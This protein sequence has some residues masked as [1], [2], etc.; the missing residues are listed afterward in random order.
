MEESKMNEKKEL[1]FLHVNT[2]I[3]DSIQAA[4]AEVPKRS[5]MYNW[6]LAFQGDIYPWKNVTKEMLKDYD[7]IQVNMSRCDLILVPQIRRV[8]NSMPESERPMLVLNNDYVCEFWDNFQLHPD[9]YDE[10]QKLGDMVFSTEHYQVSNMIEGTFCFPHP[11]NTK[12]LKKLRGTKKSNTVAFIYHWWC[13][14]TYTPWRIANKIKKKY[15]LDA[16]RIYAYMDPKTDKMMKFNKF[17]W[18]EKIGGLDFVD[19]VEHLAS[20][21]L[22][23]ELTPYHTYG[24]NTV[25]TACCKIPVIG[26]DRVFSCRENYPETSCDPYDG[27][28]IMR[29]ADKWMTDEKWA[30]RQIDM[31]F[32]K[33][34]YFNYENSR[35]RFMDALEICKKR[36]G[37]KYYQRH[38]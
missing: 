23:L 30:Q 14:D 19:Y 37:W 8:L 33:V 24:R 26:S 38:G 21:K 7:V 6:V 5:G 34:E 16:T 1:K 2:D 18:D 35:K 36:G 29:L 13:G 22:V 12:Y 17:M 27:E 9:E 10:L 32:E 11:T 31:A 4:M 20:N 3:T 25:E 15:N 28:E